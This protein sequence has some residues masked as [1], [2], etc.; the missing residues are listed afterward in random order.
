[1]LQIIPLISMLLTAAFAAP[2]YAQEFYAGKT[3]RMIDSMFNLR[4]G[5]VTKL[6]NILAESNFSETK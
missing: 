2:L 4:P 1:M 5:I 6:A 3:I